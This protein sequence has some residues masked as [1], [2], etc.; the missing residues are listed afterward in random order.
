MTRV[1]SIVVA[2]VLDLVV[3]AVVDLGDEFV[4]A[5]DGDVLVGD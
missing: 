4:V 3:D 5:L 2:V 1:V